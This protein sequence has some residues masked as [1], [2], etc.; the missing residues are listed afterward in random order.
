MSAS[1]TAMQDEPRAAPPE[2]ASALTESET[3]RG[4]VRKMTLRLLPLLFACY[5]AA[6]LD[7]VNVSFAKLSMLPAL[8][9]SQSEY[10]TGAGIFFIGYFLFEVPSNLVLLRVGARRWIAR[11][12]LLWGVVSCCMALTTGPRS[13]FALRFLLGAAEAGFFL[14]L[15][16]I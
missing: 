8:G 11:I 13:F 9:L 10:A 7:R 3:E 5:I 1:D 14:S 15:I 4:V 2:P 6:F 16:H 12:M